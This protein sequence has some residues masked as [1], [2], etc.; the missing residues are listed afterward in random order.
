MLPDLTLWQWLLVELGLVTLAVLFAQ[1]PSPAQRSLASITAPFRRLSARPALCFA[2]IF[3]TSV[4]VRLLLLTLQPV[5]IPLFHDEFSY[6]LGGDTFFHL[7]LTNPTPPVPVAFETIHTDLWPTYQSMYM[8]GPALLLFLGELLGKPWIAVLLITAAFCATLYWA[9]SAW[10]PRTWALLAAAI[11]LGYTGSL[12]WWFDNYFCLGLSCFASALILGS[13]PRIARDLKPRSTLPLAVGLVLLMLTRPYEGLCVALPCVLVLLWQLRRAG[14]TRLLALSALPSSLIALTVL[15]LLYYNWRGTGHP[16]L[17]P[18]MLNF[19]EY[20]IT[21]P[22]LFSAKHPIPQ[23]DLGMLQRFYTGAELPQYDFMR[24][25]PWDFFV[26]KVTV[27]YANFI[28]GLALPVLAGLAFL[29]RRRPQPAILRPEA[30]EH[31]EG[32]R[33]TLWL[34][35]VLAFA[36]FAFNV[37]LMAWA[38]FPQYAAP[39]APA[40]YLL[41]TFGLYGVSRLQ[42]PRLNGSRFVAGILIAELMLGLSIFGWRVSD[43]R[44]FPEPQYVSKDRARV[45]HD[46]LSHPGKQLCLVRY[47][48]YHDGWQEWVFNGADLNSERLV[49]ARSLSPETDREIIKDLPRRTVWLARPDI[50]EEMLKRY[51]PSLPFTQLDHDPGDRLGVQSPSFAASGPDSHAR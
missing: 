4:A 23:Y 35:P 36:G 2:V 48:R 9:V 33:N 14:V 15:W 5:P 46:I 31:L 50:P 42:L 47:I 41:A 27:Y 26:R 10:L 24:N 20:H 39:A 43:S 32:H 1:L 22:F 3:L 51:S 44:D 25:H 11:A 17:F 8:P 13:L 34:A 7:R 16:L 12:Q 29:V 40:L 21:G 30:N 37:V 18:Y 38:P 45:A 28:L 6:L 19:R 49:W